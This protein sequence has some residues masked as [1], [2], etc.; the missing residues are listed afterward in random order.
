MCVVGTGVR[1][2]ERLLMSPGRISP[3]E[4]IQKE[5]KGTQEHV[6]HQ[7]SVYLIIV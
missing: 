7:N 6:Y 5:E 1:K 2:N 4:I 3:Q